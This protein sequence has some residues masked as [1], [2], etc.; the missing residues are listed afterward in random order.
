MIAQRHLRRWLLLAALVGLLAGAGAW[1]VG[2]SAQIVAACWLA[3]SVPQAVMVA[4]VNLTSTTGWII[5]VDGGK[6]VG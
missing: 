3:A 5:P 6:L 1:A 2:A 4:V